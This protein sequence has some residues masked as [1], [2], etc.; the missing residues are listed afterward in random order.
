[1]FR[2]I[3]WGDTLFPTNRHSIKQVTNTKLDLTDHGGKNHLAGDVGRPSR[4]SS[5][6]EIYGENSSFTHDLPMKCD[7]FQ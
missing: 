1:M 6:M 3:T 7:H 4:V 2:G 5:Q